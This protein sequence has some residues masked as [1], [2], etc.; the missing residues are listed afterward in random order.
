MN[1][2]GYS[3]AD[4]SA[5]VRDAGLTALQD[6]AAALHHHHFDAVCPA[7]FIQSHTSQALSR[8]QPSVN[9]NDA[10]SYVK[11]S[12]TMRGGHKNR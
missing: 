1:L 3:G 5:L 2:A 12:E 10:A 4:L 11:L 9:A 6:A 7:S 8:I